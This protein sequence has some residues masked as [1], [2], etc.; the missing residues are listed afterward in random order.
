MSALLLAPLT[1]L[2]HVGLSSAQTMAEYGLSVGHSSVSSA[3]ASKLETP[4]SHSEADSANS[5]GP[6]RTMQ[7]RRDQDEQASAQDDAKDARA[8]KSAGEWEEVR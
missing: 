5:R 6:S 4:A 8:D 3:I 1:I 2:T 7:I